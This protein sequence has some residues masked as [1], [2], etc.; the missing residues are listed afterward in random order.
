MLYLNIN[1][2]VLMILHYSLKNKDYLV[3]NSY[4][5]YN[6]LEPLFSRV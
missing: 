1:S 3:A 6:F 2:S 4:L 5:D